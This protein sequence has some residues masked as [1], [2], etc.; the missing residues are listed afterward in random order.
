MNS[1]ACFEISKYS[2]RKRVYLTYIITIKTT[3]EYQENNEKSTQNIYLPLCG[4][5]NLT[6]SHLNK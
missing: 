5:E 3:S 4:I 1:R 6:D 2:T